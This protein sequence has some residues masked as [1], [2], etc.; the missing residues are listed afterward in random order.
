MNSSTRVFHPCCIRFICQLFLI[1]NSIIKC[2]FWRS[3]HCKTYSHLWVFKMKYCTTVSFD[4]SKVA[5]FLQHR[6]ISRMSTGSVWRMFARREIAK[7]PNMVSL[8][9]TTS[10][11]AMDCWELKRPMEVLL[12]ASWWWKNRSQI[13]QRMTFFEF[14]V[15]ET[16]IHILVVFRSGQQGGFD[17]C[18][19]IIPNLS[20][21]FDDCMLAGIP[22]YHWP[23]DFS[24]WSMHST[25][26]TLISTTTMLLPGREVGASGD[27]HQT[28]EAGKRRKNWVVGR[29]SHLWISLLNDGNIKY[30]RPLCS[31]KVAFRWQAVDISRCIYWYLFW[32]WDGNCPDK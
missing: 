11:R 8:S 2:L 27:Y 19:V 5:E 7:A 29:H 21:T 4:L 31:W 17:F 26:G 15:F 18:R 24:L 3:V 28:S 22:N 13:G 1:A 16:H 9:T 30:R 6:G 12:Q 32:P 10:R 25:P 20:S 14:Y 23:L